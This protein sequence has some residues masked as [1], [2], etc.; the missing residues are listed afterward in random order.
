MATAA[1]KEQRILPT[2]DIIAYDAACTP[3]VNGGHQADV[4]SAM[5]SQTTSL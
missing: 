4:T 5:T 2:D 1:Y 3:V